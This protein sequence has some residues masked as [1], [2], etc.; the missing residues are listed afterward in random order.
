[1]S[2][3]TLQLTYYK[4]SIPL[5]GTETKQVPKFKTTNTQLYVPIVTLSTHENINY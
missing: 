4:K 1:M 5:A 2:F 3:I